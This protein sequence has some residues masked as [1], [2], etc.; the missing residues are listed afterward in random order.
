MRFFTL[1]INSKKSRGGK[2]AENQGPC[3]S[4]FP[5]EGNDQIDKYFYP[6]A[7]LLTVQPA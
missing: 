4:V 6:S 5:D 3:Y 7:V 2:L 1:R